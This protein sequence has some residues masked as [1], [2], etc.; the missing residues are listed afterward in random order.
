MAYAQ[1]YMIFNDNEWRLLGM[2][3]PL[4]WE[5]FAGLSQFGINRLFNLCQ[6]PDRVWYK[7]ELL[8]AAIELDDL[9]EGGSPENPELEMANY[10]ALAQ[11]ILRYREAGTSVAV[12]CAGGRGR[13][14]TLLGVVAVLLGH[15]PQEV[16]NWLHHLHLMRTGKPWPES[17]WQSDFVASL[18]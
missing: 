13:T 6:P 7:T 11:Q 15:R 17:Q 5:S 18:G 14:G 10:L 3:L 2:G 4:P 12:H 9:H 16:V 1:P 8:C